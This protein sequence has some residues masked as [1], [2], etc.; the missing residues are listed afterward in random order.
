[1]EFEELFYQNQK[2]WTTAIIVLPQL[3]AISDT[4]AF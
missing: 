1:V 2:P 4:K 3:I